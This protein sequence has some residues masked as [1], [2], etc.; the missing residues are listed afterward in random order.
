MKLTIPDFLISSFRTNHA[1]ETGAVF[2]YKAILMVSRDHEDR[3]FKN[4]L[5][6]ESEHLRMIE[7]ILEKKYRSK[8][9]PLWKVAGFLTGFIPSLFGKNFIFATIYYVESFVE[10][11]YE[12]QIKS[13]GSIKK[14]T[15]IKKFI[16][17][18]QDDEVSHKNEA[19]F[20]AKKFSTLQVLWGRVINSGSSFAV[21][22]S[23]KNL[24]IFYF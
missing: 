13:L 3:F 10:K 23:K 8:L 22:L 24:T 14:Y 2:I 1:G 15:H 9:I 7:E 12:Q 5:K 16:K 20:S 18:L 4:H 6:T 19:R 21:K 11:H 17:K